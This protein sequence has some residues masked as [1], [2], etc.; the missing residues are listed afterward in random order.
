MPAERLFEA[1]RGARPN[2]YVPYSNFP[3][4]CAIEGESGGI[5]VGVNVDNAS[6]PET[7]CA[8]ANAIGVMVTA[9]ERR[10]RAV[11][12]LGGHPGSAALCTPCG[13]CRQRLG[14][15]ASGEVP[16]YVCNDEG[17]QETLTF[18]DLLPRA[19]GPNNLERR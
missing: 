18:G 8:E 16:V 2:A 15:F 4:S 14:E 5:F 9:G 13:G 11:L 19:F 3:V 10:I 1:A 17:V 6:Y 7:A 12:V